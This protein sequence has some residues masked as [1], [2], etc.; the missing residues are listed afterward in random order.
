MVKCVAMKNTVIISYKK[1][2]D[3]QAISEGLL[4]TYILVDY[5]AQCDNEYI[6]RINHT[7][8]NPHDVIGNGIRHAYHNY[9][10]CHIVLINEQTSIDEI[11]KII[12]EL[13]SCNDIIFASSTNTK[14]LNDKQIKGLTIITKLY[15]LVHKQ[16]IDNV[17]C[18]VQAIPNSL[19]KNFIK[20]KGASC[21]VFI[22][23]HFII[24][25]KG[26]KIRQVDV[27]SNVHTDAP[28]SIM[29]IIHYCFLIGW[30][31]I[32]F[33]I[34]SVSSFLVDYSLCLAGYA[35]WSAYVIEFFQGLSF[36]LPSAM[37]DVEI[38][39]TA[40]ARIISSIYNYNV[41]KHLVFTNKN[42]K[43]KI[44]T[45]CK[46]FA[47]VLI[48][49]ILNTIILKIATTYIGLPFAIAKIIADI[50]M[51]FVSFTVQRDVVFR[52]NKI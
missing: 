1:R 35:F 46:Y 50:I 41:N 49:W 30:V 44:S 43:S 27:D 14:P 3:I 40:I 19:V 32:K 9:P 20:L 7:N 11:K 21:R 25:D 28:E 26:I 18:N 13:E 52:K 37:L 39:S 10:N 8:L 2:E 38:V 45:I 31:F 5:D 36:A 47:L 51:Y 22:N 6:V 23:E 16:N 15:N 33:M 29:S 24:R 34:A 48:I 4:N 17:A 12:K 42:Q